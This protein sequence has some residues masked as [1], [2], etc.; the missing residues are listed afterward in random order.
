MNNTIVAVVSSEKTYQRLDQILFNDAFLYN[1][2][3]FDL[4][5]VFNSDIDIPIKFK[6]NL[7]YIYFREN[8]GL[9]PG[10]F[11][12]LIQKLPEYEYYIL[13]HDDHFF[14]DINW[15]DISINL[16]KLNPNIDIIGNILFNQLPPKLQV[17][18]DSFIKSLHLEH[19][20]KFSESPLFIHAMAGIYR[21]KVIIAIKKKYGSIPFIQNNDK[22]LAMFCERLTTLLVNDFSFKYAQFPGEIFTFL[23]HSSVDHLST[24]FSE[25][26]KYSSLNNFD[27]AIFYFEKYIHF[28]NKIN[29]FKD[30][31]LAYAHLCYL[32][33]SINNINL[34]KY[35]FKL[36]K[37]CNLTERFLNEII[38]VF[39][40]NDLI[41]N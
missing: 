2:D 11:N 4:A 6:T 39:E 19:I 35:Y 12:Y 32:Y 9:D 7:D 28:A 16:M 33:K 31:Y 18:F 14:L 41:K 36:L 30:I 25:G 24:Y 40:I 22:L 17:L 38:E 3:K 37:S 13:L 8:V 23:Y 27:K 20:L 29:N 34:A 1:R 26:C 21:K 15:F 5:V 10:G